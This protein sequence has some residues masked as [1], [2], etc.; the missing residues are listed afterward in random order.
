MLIAMV[1]RLQVGMPFRGKPL[2][3]NVT[4][5]DIRFSE[6]IRLVYFGNRSK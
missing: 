1:S 6:M 2:G 3:K 5:V 4:S